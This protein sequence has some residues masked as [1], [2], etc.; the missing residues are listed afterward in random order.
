MEIKKILIPTDFSEL[1]LY[2]IDYA[3]SIANIHGSNVHLFHVIE[4]LLTMAVPG[5]FYL[6]TE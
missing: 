6:N 3:V 2:A 4:E 1:S 5:D